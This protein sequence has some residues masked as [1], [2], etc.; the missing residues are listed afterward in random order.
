MD[1]KELTDLVVKS[2][3]ERQ[4][5]AHSTPDAQAVKTVEEAQELL[6]A[7][8][9]GKEFGWPTLGQ[10]EYIDAVGDIL[11]TLIIGCR[12]RDLDMVEC[13]ASAYDQIKDRKGHLSPEGIFVKD[14]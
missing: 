2:A 5:L 10:A 3:D 11:V 4:I 12:M 14:A 9:M 13:L 1:L 7:A 6:D 8:R